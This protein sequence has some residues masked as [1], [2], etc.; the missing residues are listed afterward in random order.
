MTKFRVWTLLLVVA[1]GGSVYLVGE[2]F[3]AGELRDAVAIVSAWDSRDRAWEPTES[4]LHALPARARFMIDSQCNKEGGNPFARRNCY[5]EAAAW[6]KDEA[7]E[8]APRRDLGLAGMLV[9]ALLGGATWVARR[10]ARQREQSLR[11]EG[12]G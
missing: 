4:Q 8:Q 10:N 1:F 11:A 3:Q 9:S 5:A 12:D 6:M 7:R 2:N